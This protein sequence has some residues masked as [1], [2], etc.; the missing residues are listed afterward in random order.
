MVCQRVVSGQ[1]RAAQRIKTAGHAGQA[2]Q[3]W[4]N[5][6]RG[7]HSPSGQRNAWMISNRMALLSVELFNAQKC[8]RIVRQTGSADPV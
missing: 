3:A 1:Q 4:D 5:T 7:R 6:Q 2:P 8:P